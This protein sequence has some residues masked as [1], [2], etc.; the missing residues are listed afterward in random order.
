MT[1][2]VV[3]E[4]R[5]ERY[6]L[7]E[8]SPEDA[9]AVGRAASSDPKVRAALD[10]LERS[11]REILAQYPPAA[12]AERLL[13]LLKDPGGR[14]SAAWARR[15]FAAPGIQGRRILAVASA[16]AVV[17]A[18]VLT[19]PRIRNARTAGPSGRDLT[20]VKGDAGL[21]L[22]KTQLLVFRKRGDRAEI[23]ADG[24]GATTGSLLQLAYVS[25]SE[26]HGVILSIDGRGGVIRH[27]PTEESGSTS[28]VLNRKSLIPN[29]IELDDAPGFERF[30]LVTSDAPIDV[31]DVIARA[32]ELA[33]NPELARKS[34]LRLPPGLKQ[35]SV[36]I[37]KEGDTR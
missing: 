17:L 25:A 6:F 14:P 11:N 8:L 5:L 27:F 15:L 22:A 26:T 29:A 1:D 31:A 3:S 32:A 10:G 7:G 4:Y 9:E 20:I 18:V 24:N 34:D 13:S 35:R 33:G 28:L 19:V 30:F 23:M 21:D 36:L 12:F 16:A 2:A 37:L